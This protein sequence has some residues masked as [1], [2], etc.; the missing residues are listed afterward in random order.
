MDGP[1]PYDDAYTVKK[2]SDHLAIETSGRYTYCAHCENGGVCCI[3][4]PSPEIYIDFFD[5]LGWNVVAV[6]VVEKVFLQRPKTFPSCEYVIYIYAPMINTAP[7]VM[8]LM[9]TDQLRGQVRGGP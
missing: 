2:A 7:Y 8:F 9:R 1:E 4:F 6:P 5:D 3:I